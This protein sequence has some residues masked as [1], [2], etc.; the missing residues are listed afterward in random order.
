MSWRS[1]LPEALLIESLSF[2]QCRVFKQ[3]YELISQQI[4]GPI[5]F[6]HFYRLSYHLLFYTLCRLQEEKFPALNR[7]WEELSG[8]FLTQDFDDNLFLYH[9]L[10]CDFPIKENQNIVLVDTFT[11]LLLTSESFSEE[12]SKDLVDFHQCL[13]ASRLGLYQANLSTDTITTFRELFTNRIHY[14]VR[15]IEDYDPMDIFLTR[16]VSYW[17]DT[18]QIQHPRC[19]GGE[20]KNKIMEMVR[21]KLHILRPPI[22]SITESK[23]YEVFMKLAGPYWLSC[24]H[25]YKDIPILPPNHFAT[26]YRK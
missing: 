5:G 16:L 17:G 13:K 7:A 4:E 11:E 19:F 25:G 15:S 21:Q 22:P 10:W 9:W 8:L 18:F 23:S 26:Y 12:D 14:T 1:L 20:F 2:D 6:Q 24:T 3:Y